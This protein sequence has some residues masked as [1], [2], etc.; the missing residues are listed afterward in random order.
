LCA[1]DQANIEI[2]Q[3]LTTFEDNVYH[4][5]HSVYSRLNSLLTKIN[6]VVNE[7]TV[8]CAAYDASKQETAALK[9]TVDTLSRKIDEQLAIPAPPSPELSASPTTM[10]EMMM[11]LS[12]VQHD[13]QDVLEAV[14]SPPG[15][16][17]QCTSKQD[18]EPTMPTN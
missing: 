2:Q 7:K 15:K 12:V 5:F 18:A 8:L 3:R 11:Q 9:A 10:E 4:S 6:T 16:R 14:R 1:V 17:K 13:I